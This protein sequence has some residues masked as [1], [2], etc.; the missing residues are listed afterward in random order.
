MIAAPVISLSIVSHGQ[1]NLVAA[2]LSDINSLSWNEKLPFEV[3]VTL[4]V[5][6]DESWLEQVFNFPL[7]IIRNESPKGFG[8]NHNSA[9]NA[10][11][12]QYFAVVNPDIRLF[13]F[14]ISPLINCLANYGAGV[15]GPVVYGPEGALQDS[16]R[17]F[18]SFGRL[19]LRKLFRQSSP[20]YLISSEVQQ[21]DWL[22]GMFLL[23]PS[24]IYRAIRGFDESYFMY[25]EDVEICRLLQQRGFHVV[26]VT[27]VH[28][29]H[30]AA[31]ASRRSRQH[32]KW[33]L[34]S[35]LRYF[36]AR[37]RK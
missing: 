25:M 21:V 7:K 8:T 28:V 11:Q 18:P 9:H 27:S 23:F 35:M 22:A 19:L 3:I 14:Q 15:C 20:D 32:M 16:A 31:R 1:S 33:H 30:D 24:D 26:W 34:T 36:F 17:C 6:E 29:V 12:G 2:L 13:D 10:S 4:N 37:S 5:P